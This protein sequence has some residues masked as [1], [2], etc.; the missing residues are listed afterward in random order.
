MHFVRIRRFM[1]D[2]SHLCMTVEPVVL[3]S[4]LFACVPRP[5]FDA[6]EQLDGLDE[7]EDEVAQALD[8][9]AK[10]SRRTVLHQVCHV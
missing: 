8:A 4:F 6:P 3:P 2:L 5:P 1:K 7:L 9:F 10:R